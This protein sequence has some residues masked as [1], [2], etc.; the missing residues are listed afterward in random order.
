MFQ[1]TVADMTN[2]CFEPGHQMVKCDP[3]RGK[4]M[5]RNRAGIHDEGVS[6]FCKFIIDQLR[7]I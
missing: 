3:R 5:V 4:Y 7:M 2:A 6:S 1:N